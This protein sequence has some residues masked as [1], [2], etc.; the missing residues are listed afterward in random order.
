LIG[1][2]HRVMFVGVTCGCSSELVSVMTSTGNNMVNS[3]W[4]A[5]VKGC[6]KPS[7]SSTRSAPS[8]PP[9]SRGHV[10][11]PRRCGL[12]LQTG[13]AWSVGSSVC[14]DRE[15]CKMTELIDMPFDMLSRVSPRNHVLDGVHIGATWQIRLNCLCATSTCSCVKSL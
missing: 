3:I 10:S 12:L 6:Q 11:V 13:V 5:N 9:S 8:T 1:D 15:P 2:H 14:H 4:E 7:A